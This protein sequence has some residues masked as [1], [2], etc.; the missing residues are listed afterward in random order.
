MTDVELY[1]TVN[2]LWLTLSVMNLG[3]GAIYAFR[4]EP[5]RDSPDSGDAALR[6]ASPQHWLD[7]LDET[8]SKPTLG[9]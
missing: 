2:S 7:A 4:V 5:E 1:H 8:P 6:Y 3:D 9:K